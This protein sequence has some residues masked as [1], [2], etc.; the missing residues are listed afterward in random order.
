MPAI[1]ESI[2]IHI[3]S[4]NHWVTSSSLNHEVI[5]DSKLRRGELSSTLIYQLC[6]IYRTLIKVEINGSEKTG[7]LLCNFFIP[8]S[9]KVEVTVV[10]LQLH[11]HCMQQWD[12]AHVS[13]LEFD[14]LKRETTF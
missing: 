4:G 5:Y 10:Y 8:K 1:N 3:V 11:L 9:R 7:H 6:L 12:T 2:Q 14:Q 13:R